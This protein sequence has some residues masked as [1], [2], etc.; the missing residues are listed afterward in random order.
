MTLA[1][2]VVAVLLAFTGMVL[3]APIYISLLQRL[4]F[5]KQIRVEGP[6]SHFAKAGTPTIMPTIPMA[7]GMASMLMC[8]SFRRSFRF[9]PI[10]QKNATPNR[11]RF[12]GNLR[13]PV[14]HQYLTSISSFERARAHSA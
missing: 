11:D 7:R 14:S 12:G 1:P 6:A 13:A 4:G 2:I 3:L 10:R 5:G 8:L 9:S